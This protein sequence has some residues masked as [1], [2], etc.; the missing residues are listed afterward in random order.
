MDAGRISNAIALPETVLVFN[1]QDGQKPRD[2]HHLVMGPA[3]FFSAGQ[4]HG[5]GDLINAVA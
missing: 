3:L 4:Q 1:F 5:G 2:K